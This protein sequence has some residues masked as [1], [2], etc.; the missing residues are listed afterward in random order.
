MMEITF[1]GTSAGTPTI[2]RNV[3]GL[4]L[5]R[6]R[7]WDLFDCGEATQHRLL[8]TS[9]SMTRL[10]RIFVSHLHGDH[11]FGL[12]GLLGSRSMD[13]AV[14]PLTIIG[15]VGLR[16]MVE[17]VVAGSSAHIGFPIEFVEVDTDGGVVIDDDGGTVTALPLA[18]RVTSF[19]WLIEEPTRPG[20][21]D[22]AAATRLGVDPGPSFG[23]L[24]RGE[25]VML[26]DGRQVTPDNVMGTPR[27]GRRIVIA[28]DNSAPDALLDRT[29]SVDVLVHEATYTEPVLDAL[30]DDHGHSTAGRVAR[31]AR[32][33]GVGS[34]VLTH[35]SPRYAS[36]GDT[37]IDDVR[38]EARSQFDGVHLA[39]DLDRFEITPDG[40]LRRSGGVE[41][42]GEV[43]D[44]VGRVLDPDR[45]PDQVVGNLEW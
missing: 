9:L 26:A 6:G 14:S 23:R 36:G 31:A 25:E 27:P 18:H 19:A 29:G 30:G 16:S 37:T 40:S 44:E 8:H 42:G 41:G 24:Q 12:F 7:R 15:P 35:F 43:V 5:R 34:L 4:A 32:V 17:T 33:H 39:S 10:R 2:E 3:S 11:W 13:R 1:L 45:Q 20:R 28:G 38:Q 21:L 22:A